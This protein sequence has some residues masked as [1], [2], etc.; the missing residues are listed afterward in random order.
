MDRGKHTSLAGVE[1]EADAAKPVGL[2]L[3]TGTGFCHL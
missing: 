3:G 2:A 1:P